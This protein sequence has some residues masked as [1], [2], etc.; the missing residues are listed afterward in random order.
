MQ[1][2]SVY[3]EITGF[4]YTYGKKIAGTGTISVDGTVGKIGGVSQKI[5]TAIHNNAD[6]FLCPA[7]NYEE[8]LATY[9]KTPNHEKMI[10]IKVSTFEEAINSLGGLYE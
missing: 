3:S 5:V 7:D 2:L 9:L 6:V 1:T 10:L 8:A 4:D